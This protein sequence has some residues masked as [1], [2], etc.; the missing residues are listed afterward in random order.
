MSS[1]T[2]LSLRAALGNGLCSYWRSR[3]MHWSRLTWCRLDMIVGTSWVCWMSGMLM[4]HEA[5]L[6]L[7]CFDNWH[8]DCSVWKLYSSTV[9]C[10]RHFSI[11]DQLQ[12]PRL[13]NT[14]LR[15]CEESHQ[16]AAAVA[17]CSSLDEKSLRADEV[18]YSTA[19]AC[20][21]WQQA[22]LFLQDMHR[23][24]GFYSRGG[25]LVVGLFFSPLVTPE[26]RKLFLSLSKATK[27][28]MYGNE[29]GGRVGTWGA[30]ALAVWTKE[31]T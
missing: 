29:K 4:V 14:T 1:P 17:L 16:Q 19:I 20:V 10:L 12:P 18:T 23:T 27:V 6:G 30:G 24:L 22:F 25:M 13:Y 9:V 26:W 2:V 21:E 3:K 31:Q 7:W 11:Q 28:E 15:A 8:P 5:F